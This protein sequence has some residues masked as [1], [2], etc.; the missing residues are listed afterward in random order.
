MV[1]HNIKL[2]KVNDV[3]EVAPLPEEY[4][5]WLELPEEEKQKTMKPRSFE[6]KLDGDS[7]L[8]SAVGNSVENSY[9]V[10]YDLRDYNGVKP[11]KNQRN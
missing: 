11:V 10:K 3:I 8:Q 4:K 5:A 6:V 1:S 2:T 7:I 9:P